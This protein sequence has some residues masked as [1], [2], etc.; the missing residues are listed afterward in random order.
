MKAI[1]RLDWGRWLADCPSP[2]CT[3]AMVLQ[4]GQEEFRCRFLAGP[5]L[6]QYGGCGTVASIEWPDDKATVD[7]DMAGRAES[8]QNW[9]PE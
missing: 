1:A 8:E 9:R 4:P 7:A 2:T 6:D 5:R 3:N